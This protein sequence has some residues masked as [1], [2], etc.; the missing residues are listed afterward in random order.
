VGGVADGI[1]EALLRAFGTEV[2]RASRR[3]SVAPPGS[4]LDSSAFRILWLL[5]EAGPRSLQELAHDLQLERSTVNRQVNAALRHGLV[6][7][8]VVPGRPGRSL[9][10]T[11]AGLEAYQ[12]DAALR[13]EVFA[14]VLGELG[15]VR[16]RRLLEDLQAFN[17]AYDRAQERMLTG[18]GLGGALGG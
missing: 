10:P 18:D 12:H 11:S 4:L 13:G 5:V 16:S 2:M 6:E 1:D 8:F 9:R 7:R 17:D 14:D 15:A 3:R